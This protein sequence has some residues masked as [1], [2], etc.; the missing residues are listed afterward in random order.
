MAII[1]FSRVTKHFGDVRA[2]DDVSFSISQG[3]IFG[4]IGYSGAGKSTLVRLINALE[5]LTSGSLTVTGT[6]VAGL[7]EAKLRPLRSKIGMIFQHF[8]L[9]NSRSV[10]SNIAYPLK[11]AGW[12]R[13]QRNARVLELLD[14]VGLADK[15]RSYPQ[16]LSG[17]QKQ[18]VGIARALASGPDILLADEPTSALDPET[19]RDVLGLLRR[20][21]EELG[22]TIVVITH[23][24]NVVREICHRVAVMENGKVAELGS[25]YDV[26]TRPEAPVTQAFVSTAL[27]DRPTPQAL[28]RLRKRYPGRLVTISVDEESPSS[29]EIIELFADAGVKASVVYGAITEISGRGAGSLTYELSGP[30]A[31][32]V[33][34]SLTERASITDW[35][36]RAHET[37]AGS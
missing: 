3:E 9:M 21:N 22:V 31:D 11:I 2:V 10:S 36:S 28:E 26:F 19:T 4:V 23:E 15:A 5:P 14:F 18:R 7:P 17:G 16:Q 30:D 33:V 12:S 29:S 34:A 24:M 27:N 32:A 25:T 6:D 8:N 13:E 20:V 35:G 37:E 1:N